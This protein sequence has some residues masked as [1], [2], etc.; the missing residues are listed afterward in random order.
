[1]AVADDTKAKL[2][3]AAGEEF[4]A[5]GFDG[6]AVRSICDRAGVKNLASISY[7]FGSKERLYVEAV[8]EAH[9]CATHLLP[10]SAFAD[11]T[12]AEHLRRYI[13]HFLS[14]VLAMRRDERWHSAL[15]LREMLQPTAASDVLVREAIRPRFERLIGILRRACPQ[16]GARRLHAMAFSVVGQCLHYKTT[17]PISERLIGVEA[18]EALDLDYLTDHI[19]SFCLAALGLGAPLCVGEGGDGDRDEGGVR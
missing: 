2:L 15:I 5:K 11:G 10:E 8:L 1:M 6:A 4:A 14:D 17:R 19:T 7:H 16:A 13:H 9:R 12:P 3:E 18:Y